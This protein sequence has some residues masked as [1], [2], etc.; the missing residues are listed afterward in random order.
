MRRFIDARWPIFAT[1]YLLFILLIVGILLAI[2]KNKELISTDINILLPQDQFISQSQKTAEHLLDQ[3]VNRQIILL[4]GAQHRQSAFQ[5]ASELAEKW[6]HSGLFDTVQEQILPDFSTLQADAEH[7]Q[8]AILPQE[9]AEQLI[10]EPSEYFRQR[11]RDIINP[12][13]S[14]SMMELQQD[15]LGLGRFIPRKLNPSGRLQWDEQTGMLFVQEGELTWVWVH[16]M[17]PENRA[18]SGIDT[19][20]LPLLAQTERQ[21]AKQQVKTRMAGA[22]IFAAENKMEAEKES[23]LMSVL[24]IVLSLGLLL[25]VFRSGR[26]LALLLPVGGGVVLGAA[27]CIWWFGQI[28]ILTLVIGSSLVGVLIDFPVHWLS[29]ALWPKKWHWYKALRQ[30]MPVFLLSFIVTAAGYAALWLTPLPIL[31]QTAVFSIIALAGAFIGTVALMPLFLHRW[32]P[33]PNHFFIRFSEW[34]CTHFLPFSRRA[35][36][37][38]FVFLILI[39]LSGLRL[40]NWQDDIRQWANL[41]EKWLQEGQEVGRLTG[42]L[43]AGQ[44]FLVEAENEETLLRQNQLLSDRLFALQEKKALDGFQAINMW[45]LS[46]DEQKQ[47]QKALQEI[48]KQPQYWADIHQLGVPDGLI[49]NALIQISHMNTLS[50]SESLDSILAQAWRPLWLG[51]TDE[52]TIS[53]IVFLRGIHDINAV[54]SA[55]KDIEGVRWVDRPARLNTLFAQTRN[56]AVQWKLWSYFLASV[57]LA[58]FLPWRKV[59]LILSVPFFAAVG[60]IAILGLLGTPLSLFAIFGLLLVSAIGVDYA[61]YAALAVDDIP[62]RLAGILLAALT[63]IISFA[64]LSLSS[65]PAVSGFGLSVAIGVLLNLLLTI[66]LFVYKK[67]KYATKQSI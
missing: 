52:N 30:V 58:L 42:V 1:A 6:R 54:Y 3:S 61:T 25:W 66:G 20:L 48:Q 56:Q 39:L 51:K 11:A 38:L 12:F 28:H 34:I 49:E 33:K 24:G 13:A 43:P 27:A 31:R 22:A 17:L 9:Q 57:L 53:S 65:T 16:A 23:R 35:S 36:I 59:L 18:V 29:L 10:H 26:I 60:T 46:Q 2:G 8:L 14:I 21:A 15:W 50:I 19:R 4:V 37:L 55:A 62:Q 32:Q 41:S 64:I 45:V 40:S 44:F 5:A 67:E 7:L 47:V 63:T